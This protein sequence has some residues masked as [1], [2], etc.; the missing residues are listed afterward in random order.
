MHNLIIEEGGYVTQ[1]DVIMGHEQRAGFYFFLQAAHRSY[2]Y[3]SIN[4]KH[5]ERHY[6]RSVIYPVWWDVPVSAMSENEY[7]FGTDKQ[8]DST[9]LRL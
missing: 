4:A 1:T 2:S 8:A 7:E 3:D 9:I 6:V 5:L